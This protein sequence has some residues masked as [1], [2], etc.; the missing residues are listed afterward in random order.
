MIDSTVFVE[1]KLILVVK[2]GKPDDDNDKGL[3]SGKIAGIVIGV[4][5]AFVAIIVVVIVIIWKRKN[6]D[7]SSNEVSDMV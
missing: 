5:V 7:N 2:E 1:I 4:V 3:N 6:K